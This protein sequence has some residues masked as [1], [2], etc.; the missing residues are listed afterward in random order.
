MQKEKQIAPITHR[1]VNQLVQYWQKRGILRGRE[2]PSQLSTSFQ[3]AFQLNQPT[4]SRSCFKFFLKKI[5]VLRDYNMNIFLKFLTPPLGCSRS[6][7]KSRKLIKQICFFLYRRSSTCPPTWRKM[8]KEA[9]YRYVKVGVVVHAH[10][11]PYFLWQGSNLG[12]IFGD[13]VSG[14]EIPTNNSLF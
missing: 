7:L 6:L 1:S 12:H 10:L 9:R 13:F 3:P 5:T 8:K 11:E 14:V 2:C 4:H